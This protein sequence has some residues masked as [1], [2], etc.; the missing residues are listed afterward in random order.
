MGTKIM[1]R[2]ITNYH[3]HTN[4]CDGKDTAEK[5][6]ESAYNKGVSILG[7]SSHSMYPF[8][9]SW[10]ID[11]KDFTNYCAEVQKLKTEYK[12]KMEILLGFE[13]EFIPGV[14]CPRMDEYSDFLPDYLIGAVHFTGNDNGIFAVDDS[15]ENVKKGIEKY[16]NGNGKNAVCEYFARQ[17]EMLRAGNF[18]I[19]AH[20]DLIRKRNQQ[21]HF[22]DENDSWYKKELAATAKE[23][24]K[25]GV[26]VE[27]NTGA[28]SRKAMDDVY[29]SAQFLEII[30]NQGIPVT[31]SSDSHSAQTIISDFDRAEKAAKN[32]GYSEIMYINEQ[33]QAISQ[34]L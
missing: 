12:G 15:S 26:I 32:A 21:L 3:T 8:S 28:I 25:A 1:H 10:H 9:S 17:R 2:I 6:A 20:C 33:G 27:I 7:F 16:F 22:F 19:L 13:A 24:A 23:I 4:F 31:F 14:T 5:M 30:K 18:A 34:A 11:T 29:P